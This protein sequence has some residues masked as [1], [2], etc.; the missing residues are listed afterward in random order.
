MRIKVVWVGRTKAAALRVLTEDYQQRLAKFT[1][2]EVMEVRES[3]AR[4]AEAIKTEEGE[5]VL[6]SLRTDTTVVLL[7]VE[8]KQWSSPELAQQI[9]GWQNASLKEVAFLIG[10]HLGVAPAVRQRAD[11]CWSLSRLTLTH[12]MAR[13]LL[14]EQLYRAYTILRGVPYQK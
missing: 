11:I 4:D 13:V 9:E 12:E 14:F 1:R 7:D 6:S 2:C 10:G 8:G 5:R 3:A